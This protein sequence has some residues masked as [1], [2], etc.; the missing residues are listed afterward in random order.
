MDMIRFL[1]PPRNGKD[2]SLAPW[3][4]WVTDS[5]SHDDDEKRVKAAKA[6]YLQRKDLGAGRT[7]GEDKRLKAD[8]AK[9]YNIN[10]GVLE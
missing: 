1:R 3:R 2:K 5:G 6:D 7:A 9:K 10:A 8:L 4:E